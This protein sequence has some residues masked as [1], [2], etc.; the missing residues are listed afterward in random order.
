[1]SRNKLT[2]EQVEDAIMSWSIRHKEKNYTPAE[3][4]ILAEEY[5]EDLVD[6]GFNAR[7]FDKTAKIVRK[8]AEFFPT[9]RLILE[10]R[11]I[12]QDQ[13]NR[14]SQNLQKALPEPEVDDP[15]KT[16]YN[17][18]RMDI[19]SQ[20]RKGLS[21]HNA[22]RCFEIITEKQKACMPADQIPEK[23]QEYSLW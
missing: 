6:E 2:K 7:L 22:T 12:A 8:R 4:T 15:T 5:Y 21:F 20:I 18:L 17:E 10:C 9:M 3:L 11:G 19:L 23:Y 13:I 1:M 14:D 16:P